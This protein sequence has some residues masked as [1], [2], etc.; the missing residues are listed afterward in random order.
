[1]P[2]P[3]NRHYWCPNHTTDTTDAQ[4]TQQTLL[5]PKP[6]NRH[7]WCPNHTTDT[8]D[9]QTTQQTL[10]MPKPHNRHYW[11][12][13]H[14]INTYGYLQPM[15]R[16]GGL[17]CGWNTESVCSFSLRPYLPASLPSII[18]RL[19]LFPVQII[20]ICILSVTRNRYIRLY[21]WR[22]RNLQNSKNLSLEGSFGTLQ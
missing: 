13:N 15:C 5:M 20:L 10:L 19:T 9:A 6:H 3:H 7:Y 4:T 1:M 8:T 18:L 21:Q 22:Q 17:C 14:T 16:L 2:K 12:P 11:C